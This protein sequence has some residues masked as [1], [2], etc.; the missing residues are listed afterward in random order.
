MKKLSFLFFVM[1]I[2]VTPAQ[3][4]ADVDDQENYERFLGVW[5]G[6]YGFV[7]G[8]SYD[9]EIYFTEKNGQLVGYYKKVDNREYKPIKEVHIDENDIRFTLSTIPPQYI[10]AVLEDGL[11][12]GTYKQKKYLGNILLSRKEKGTE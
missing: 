5:A 3:L 12:E 4:K 9:I 1:L 6:K 2:F 8:Y 10:D 7:P 11:I